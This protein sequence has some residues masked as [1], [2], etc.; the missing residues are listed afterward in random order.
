MIELNKI[1]NED[2]LETMKRMPDKSVDLILTDPPYGINMDSELNK[3]QGKYG[4][5]NY[6]NTNWDNK[7]PDKLIFDEMFRISKN[8]IIWGANYFVEFLKPS[9]GWI[10]W[11]K[12]QRDFSLADGELAY[13]S[14]NKALRIFNVSRS[15][16]LKDGKVHP[17]QKSI[18]IIEK[19]VF[20]A[21]RALNKKIDLIY[22]PFMGS[23]TTAIA[24]IKLNRKWIGSELSTEYCD[25]ANKRIKT[26]LSQM[27]L[28]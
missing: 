24:C 6:G 10:V 19:C 20:Y 5:K 1:Y 8:Q 21:E 15:A 12:G 17:T 23:G 22:D 4:Y 18:K 2:C 16:A 26:E 25:I 9:M 7:K 13:T 14:F 27:R 3:K 28:F 11:D